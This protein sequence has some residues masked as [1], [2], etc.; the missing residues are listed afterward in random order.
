MEIAEKDCPER[1][2]I[3]LSNRLNP[4]EQEIE[5]ETDWIFSQMITNLAASKGHM[6]LNDF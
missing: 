3:R 2:Q 5:V 4:T 6:E 1:I